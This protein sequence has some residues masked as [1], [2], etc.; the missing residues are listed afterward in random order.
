[1]S[2]V[3][4]KS[5]TGSEGKKVDLPKAFD[6]PYR[7]D[8]IKRAVLSDQTKKKQPQGRYPLAGRLTAATSVRPG[9]GL[10]LI[11]R[12]HGKGTHHG[13]RGAIVP[14]A[15]GGRLAHPPKVEKKIVEKINKKEYAYALKSAVYA[16]ADNEI[17]RTRGHR[18]DEDFDFPIIVENKIAEVSKTSDMAEILDNLGLGDE[19]D[20]AKVRSVKSGKGKMRGRRYRTPKGPLI[21]FADD[22]DGMQAAKNIPGV[23]AARI[24]DLSVEDLAPG[25]HAGRITIWTE[26]AIEEMALEIKWRIMK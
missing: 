11:P 25:T 15:R 1:M 3:T 10:S 22:C 20:R 23:D 4:I 24:R 13:N 8:L 7:P 17:V 14:S 12:T 19:L 18:I 26:G 5:I 9:R 2:K 6:T 16:T 21:V